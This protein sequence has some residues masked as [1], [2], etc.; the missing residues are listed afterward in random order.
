MDIESKGCRV[1]RKPSL[2]DKGIHGHINREASEADVA[3]LEFVYRGVAIRTTHPVITAQM[4]LVAMGDKFKEA[5]DPEQA[6]GKRR[7]ANRMAQKHAEDVFR[8]VAMMTREES[9]SS[10]KVVEEVFQSVAFQKAARSFQ[11]YCRDDNLHGFES[12]R[13]KWHPDDLYPLR[14]ILARWLTFADG[15]APTS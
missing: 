6:E 5:F 2:G 12:V 4:K 11:D 7:N 15:L 1:K 9:D 8:A 13:D 14:D 10:Q 3:A